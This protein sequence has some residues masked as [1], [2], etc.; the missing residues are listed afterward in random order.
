M[1]S[2]PPQPIQLQCPACG[3]P[4][5][6]AIF[7]LVDGGE[8]PEL[9]A[10]LI[11]G[12]INVAVCPQCRTPSMLA[13][14]LI[15]H[16]AEKQL[17]LV[18][19]PQESNKRPADQD[20]FLGEVT[21]YL[22]KALPQEAPRAHLLA[23][24]RFLSMQSLIEAVLQADGL[25]LDDMRR[26]EMHAQ[27]LSELA[28][29]IDDE[30]AFT[31]YL[32]Q[33][34]AELTPE[35]FATLQGFIDATPQ[36]QAETRTLLESLR[37]RLQNDDGAADDALRA[38]LEQ[39]LTRLID[40]DAAQLGNIVAELRP[41]IDYTFFDVWT[42]QIESLAAA[43]DETRAELLTQRRDEVI[44]L[45]D[46]MDR[47]AQELFERGTSLLQGVLDQDDPAAAL[48]ARADEVDQ[49]LLVVISANVGAA[50][51]AGQYEIAEALAALGEVVQE[52]V[53]ERMTPEDRFIHELLAQE[54]PQVATKL[55]RRSF[56]QITPDLIKRLNELAEQ[57]TQRGQAEQA[58]L[59]RQFAREAGAMLF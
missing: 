50:Q 6:A 47:E 5:R 27:L 2:A 1:P 34:R 52:I 32:A 19:L 35:F 15:Y 24:R 44:G 25:T 20:R 42:E 53:T 9:K 39:A 45:I 31:S 48:R 23:P 28:S 33:R 57:E 46:A 16:D 26:Q 56:A 41:L 51:R 17:C 21:G 7:T 37:D 30:R 3:T 10:A 58:G 55:L 22:M 36:E 14:P 12:Q 43:G 11:S 38:E 54:T 4:F 8:Q 49:D 13:A 59:L 29:L 18:Y 40:A